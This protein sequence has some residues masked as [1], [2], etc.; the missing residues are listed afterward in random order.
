MANTYLTRTMGTPTNRKKFTISVWVKKSKVGSSDPQ[1][2][3]NGYYSTDNRLVIYFQ[4]SGA[5]TLGFYNVAGASATAFLLTNR[6]FRDT[7][8]WYHIVYRVDTT[9]STA[10]DRIKLYV[11]GVQETSFSNNS[12]PSQNADMT[13]TNGYTNFIGKYG[14]NTSSQFD[15]AMSHMHFCDGY[16][17][18]AT[19]FGQYDANGVWKIIVEPSVTYG[20]EGFFI[21]KDGNSVT[22]QSPN[23]NNFTV[24]GG[25]LTKT[26]D[27]PSNVFANWNALDS[28]YTQAIFSNGN[29]TVQTPNAS[30]TYCTSTLGMSSG[31]YYM[32]VEIYDGSNR[33]N[34]GIVDS[35]ST[36]N[37]SSNN[38]YQKSKGYSYRGGTAYAGV[39][40]N[41]TKL[42]G[43][44]SAYGGSSGDKVMIAVDLDNNKLYFGYNGTWQNSGDPTSG[45][46][47]TGAISITPTSD[48]SN[49][50]YFFAVGDEVTTDDTTYRANFGNGY[51]GTTAVATN[52]GNG[53]SGAEGSSIFN[54]QPPTGYS[55]LSTKGLNL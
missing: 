30:Q 35:I 55:A 9:Q 2:I 40:N 48:L 50:C 51:F 41:N 23:T 18:D 28:Y 7:N 32:E 39:W 21:L 16:A 4:N 25:T 37:N 19:A 8:A 24:G 20:N 3:W 13:F 38:L 36:G 42:S 26:E 31:K 22:D 15:G 11:N 53:Y 44:F 45:S 33:D 47:G 27:N 29:T 6:K 17:Y 1:H 10:S 14:A 5:D 54:Y 12:Y 52:S 34:I 43:T 49:G 46:T